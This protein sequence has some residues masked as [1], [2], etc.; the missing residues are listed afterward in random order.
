LR[1]RLCLFRVTLGN[2]SNEG[3]ELPERLSGGVAASTG[4]IRAGSSSSIVVRGGVGE[5]KRRLLQNPQKRKVVVVLVLELG[6][7]RG[8]ITLDQVL[9][10]RQILQEVDTPGGTA[11]GHFQGVMRLTLLACQ[12]SKI[13]DDVF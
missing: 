7:V 5:C 9:K 13:Q 3:H 2:L 4:T 6:L 8:G 12:S 1:E 10:L 11:F